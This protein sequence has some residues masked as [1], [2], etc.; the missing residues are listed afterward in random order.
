MPYINSQVQMF[1][2]IEAV[3]AEI[4]RFGYQR[5]ETQILQPA[6]LFL[7]KA[8]DQ[9]IQRLFTFERFGRQLALRPEFT[10]TAAKAYAE[11]QSPGMASIARW[12]FAG[13]VFEDS[14]DSADVYQRYSVGA[15]LI[16]WGSWLADAEVIVL[17]C[18]GLH[19]AGCNDIR[20]AIGSV[21]FLRG[22]LESYELDPRTA[23]FVLDH[24]HH[25]T[26]DGKAF[27]L[28]RFDKLS[29]IRSIESDF[30]QK[31][32]GELTALLESETSFAGRSR[33]DIL[34]RLKRKSERAA[35]RGQ[36]VQALD[37][38]EY[39][40]EIDRSNPNAP[41]VV[42]A[43]LLD[44]QATAH[45]ALDQIESLIELVKSYD[46]SPQQIEVHPLLARDWNYY[47]DIVFEFRGMTGGLIAGGGRYNELARLLG[48][49]HAP[50][51]GIAFYMENIIR[52]SALADGSSTNPVTLWLDEDSAKTAVWWASEMRAAG[53]S[54]IFKERTAG[55]ARMPGVIAEGDGTLR[56]KGE[57]YSMARLADV[58]ELAE[59]GQLHDD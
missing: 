48:G 6:D 45:R 22:L 50:A 5:L 41:Q 24:L 52:Q 43:G 27:V 16:G 36:V 57:K 42:R 19:A 58:L 14:L 4:D 29:A 18:A 31:N 11:M 34:R 39:L 1:R 21:Q 53:C 15:E 13:S 35:L 32:S 8:G 28:E 47:T 37:Q 44:H 51:V 33:E 59:E 56:C 23:Q 10:A 3:Q 46:Q 26:T 2:L 54:V 20:L 55:D 12:Q 7:T 30:V 9:F 25:L 40:Q 38:L 17:G 49:V